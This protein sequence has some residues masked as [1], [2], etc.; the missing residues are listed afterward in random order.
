MRI[1]SGAG[2]LRAVPDDVRF[3]D[4]CKPQPKPV[5]A[6]EIRTHTL[7]DR[8]RYAFLY[9]G[10]RWTVVRSM[11]VRAQPMCARCNRALTAIVDHVVPAGVAILQ[12]QESGKYISKYEGFF[13]RSNLQGLC[14]SCHWTKTNEDKL[15]VGEWP[16]VLDRDAHTIKH[17]WCF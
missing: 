14:R 16:N 11:V 5:D 17:K 2:C 12:A 8:E 13:L 10:K 1:C 7:A 3:C 9:S 15:H 4:E 6:D